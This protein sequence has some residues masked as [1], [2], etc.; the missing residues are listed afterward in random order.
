MTGAHVRI[1]C[2]GVPWSVHGPKKTGRSPNDSF[3]FRPSPAKNSFTAEFVI[4]EACSG[5]TLF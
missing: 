3:Y 5:E 4:I 2:P 1:I